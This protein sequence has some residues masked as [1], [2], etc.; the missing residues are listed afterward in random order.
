MKV[1]CVKQN[2]NVKIRLWDSQSIKNAY[3]INH[4]LYENTIALY[5]DPKIDISL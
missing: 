5:M 3:I 4:A 2:L 1:I